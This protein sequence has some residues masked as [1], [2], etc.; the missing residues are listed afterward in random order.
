MLFCSTG[1]IQKRAEALHQYLASPEAGVEGK[2]LNFIGHSMGGLDVRH[3]I[4]NIRP[5]EYTPV[6]LTTISTPHRGSPFMDW[7]NVSVLLR[8]SPRSP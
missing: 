4:T 8:D 2:K 1:S 7:C 3:L 6:S 5:T